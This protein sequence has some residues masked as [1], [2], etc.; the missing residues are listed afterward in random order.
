M[1]RG[2]QSL[3]GADKA[4]PG[5][6]SRSLRPEGPRN[7]PLGGGAYESRFLMI[8]FSSF[9]VFLTDLMFCTMNKYYFSKLKKKN[10][11]VFNMVELHT[12]YEAMRK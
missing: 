6:Q 10:S 8:L 1:I 12:V 5:P 3:A 4:P 2:R 7:Q 9:H 11:L